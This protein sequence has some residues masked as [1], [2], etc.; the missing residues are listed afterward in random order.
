[1]SQRFP[2]SFPSREG[3]ITFFSLSWVS[4][5]KIARGEDF[6]EYKTLIPFC[7]GGVTQQ[8]RQELVFGEEKNIINHFSQV[9]FFSLLL[10]YEHEFYSS[11]V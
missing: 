10:L 11:Y 8:R 7:F 2:Q 3:K 6:G 1:M 5:P 4:N 9:F